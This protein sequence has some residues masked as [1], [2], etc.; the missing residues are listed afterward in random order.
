M[1]ERAQTSFTAMRDATRE[2][3]QIIGRH[4]LEYF[5]GLPGRILTHLSLLAGD[6]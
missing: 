4:S 1:G 5:S 6:S 2:D 3:Y